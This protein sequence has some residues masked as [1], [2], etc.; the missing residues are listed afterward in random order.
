MI[1][2]FSEKKKID[3]YVFV[4]QSISGASIG[5]TLCWELY[6]YFSVS[7]SNHVTDIDANTN[8]SLVT[9]TDDT[10]ICMKPLNSH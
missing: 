6:L 7:H 3:H 1:H 4:T 10:T 9:S 8:R 2:S 5:K